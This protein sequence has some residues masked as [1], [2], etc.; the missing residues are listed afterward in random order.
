M[1]QYLYEKNSKFYMKANYFS[2]KNSI[3]EVWQKKFS[4]FLYWCIKNRKEV[5]MLLII[6]DYLSNQNYSEKNVKNVKKCKSG[7]GLFKLET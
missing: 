7:G 4:V 5:C 1:C 3:K 2:A 6:Y